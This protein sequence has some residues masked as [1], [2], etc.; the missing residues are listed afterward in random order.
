M[1]LDKA[2]LKKTGCFGGSFIFSNV[3]DLL[4][5]FKEEVDRYLVTLDMGLDLMGA[6]N[7]EGLVK[8]IAKDPLY[9]VASNSKDGEGKI[10]AG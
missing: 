8:D 4:I 1:K 7:I 10:N 3:K 2:S 6:G 5:A 9:K